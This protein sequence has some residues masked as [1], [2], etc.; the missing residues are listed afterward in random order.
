MEETN[1]PDQVVKDLEYFK[2]NCEENYLNTPIS[3]LRYISELL[4][5]EYEDLEKSVFGL[6]ATIA[7]RENYIKLV[8]EQTGI[9]SE[10]IA[11]LRA[12]IEEQKKEIE[13]LLA[14]VGGYMKSKLIDYEAISKLT[15][16]NES[17]KNK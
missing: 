14:V 2:N 3:V 15:Q 9:D 13:G 8:N 16:E 11:E 4:L 12:T 17:L 5:K 7:E 10:C 6:T 1:K